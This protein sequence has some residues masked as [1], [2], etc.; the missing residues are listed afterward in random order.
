MAAHA[1]ALA[2]ALWRSRA[3]ESVRSHSKSFA[4]RRRS[5]PETS[6]NPAAARAVC[7]QPFSAIGYPVIA[8]VDRCTIWPLRLS[9]PAKE[10]SGA[11]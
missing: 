2:V 10:Y 7:D 5:G 4:P 9:E 6:V 11:E 3:Q 8:I 1:L